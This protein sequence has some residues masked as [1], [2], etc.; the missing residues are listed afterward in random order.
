MDA[1]LRGNLFL[2]NPKIIEVNIK[3]LPKSRVG[4]CF[5]NV[6]DFCSKIKRAE[7]ILCWALY[8]NKNIIVANLHAVLKLNG[9]FCDI[10]LC[11][12]GSKV[13]KIVL[14]SRMTVQRARQLTC[15]R[16]MTFL[17]VV[18]VDFPQ[19]PGIN[20]FQEL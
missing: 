3:D 6:D 15:E 17:D 11:P 5:K 7:P 9:K 16:K 4:Y 18:S 13:R 19:S 12:L 2:E 8:E 1:F 20:F 14:E 10:T